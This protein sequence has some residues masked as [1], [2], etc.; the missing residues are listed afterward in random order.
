[1]G[2]TFALVARF[3]LYDFAADAEH[4]PVVSSVLEY[5]RERSIAVRAA[6]I[7]VPELDDARRHVKGAGNYDAMCAQCH[8]APAQPD[9]ELSRGL[10]PRPPNLSTIRVQPA[11]AFWAIKH[12]IKTSGMPAWGKS[13]SDDDIWD[14][15]AFLQ[16]LPQMD[17]Q[18]YR[19]IVAA[20]AGHMHEGAGAR[21]DVDPHDM[22]PEAPPIHSHDGRV[23]H[24]AEGAVRR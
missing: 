3:G 24:A 17:A 21:G 23:K 11:L 18:A 9:T 13:M 5:M 15:V 19:Q 8:L 4:T 14:M 1:M 16:R 22:H 2:V 10:Y 20:S 12:G 7:V 6:G